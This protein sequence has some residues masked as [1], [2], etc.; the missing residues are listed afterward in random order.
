MRQAPDHVLLA[1]LHRKKPTVYFVNSM[2]DL[3]HENVPDE[4]IDRVFAVMALSPQHTFQVLTKRAGQMR[5]YFAARG[6]LNS[7]NGQKW[8][9]LGTPIGSKIN[10]GGQWMTP[11]LPLPNVWLGV[12]AER[13][14]EADERIPL[15]LQTPAAVRFISAEPLLGPIDLNAVNVDDEIPLLR[16]CVSGD[17][18]RLD[19]V[20][21]G[22]ESGKNARPMHPEWARS[23]RDQCKAAGVAFFFKQWGNWTRWEPK[24]PATDVDYLGVDGS[25]S[26]NPGISREPMVNVGKHKAGPLL[27]GVEHNEMPR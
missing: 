9:L 8:S 12:S 5:E 6:R 17:G 25:H 15:L 1:P 23:L 20:I 24:Y 22:G 27:D 19:W 7:I 13:Q 14:Q 21:A 10:H 18:R 16:S 2:S 11:A 26:T 4:W 3:F